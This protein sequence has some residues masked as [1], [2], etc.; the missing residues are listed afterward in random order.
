MT[1]LQDFLSCGQ[2][3]SQ[4]PDLRG[5]LVDLSCRIFQVLPVVGQRCRGGVQRGTLYL[6]QLDGR[7]HIVHGSPA[8]DDR[9]RIAGK[10]IQRKPKLRCLPRERTPGY[11]CSR[12]FSR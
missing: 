10:I 8:G 9:L 6:E 3:N 1:R 7:A 11:V 5:D 4:L 2:L 12:S